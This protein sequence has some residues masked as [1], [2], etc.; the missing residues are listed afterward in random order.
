MFKEMRRK[1]KAMNEQACEE[2]LLGGEYGV[3][4]TISENGYPYLTPL[5]YA[6]YNNRIYFH[7]AINGG[8]LDNIEVNDKVSFCVVDDVKLLRAEFDT[9][10][11]SVI[12]FGHAYESKDD[13]KKLAL[14]AIIDKY[15]KDF[16]D[17]GY[18]YIEKSGIAT[19]VFGINIEHMTGKYQ[20][21]SGAK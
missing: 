3:L 20:D 1:E 17:E 12:I 5:N 6:Y 10:Y 4:G 9:D 11:K 21:S 7:S 8:K 14:K 13:E 16:V 2:L 15:S 19:R 18:K